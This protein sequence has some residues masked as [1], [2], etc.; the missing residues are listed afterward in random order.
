M[1]YGSVYH[2]GWALIRLLK[3]KWPCKKTFG[4]LPEEGRRKDLMTAAYNTV[5]IKN[6]GN[7]D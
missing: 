4:P 7:N 5:T 3:N 6:S 2:D 1:R